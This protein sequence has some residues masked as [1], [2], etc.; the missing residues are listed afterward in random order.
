MLQQGK[1]T[2][3]YG[4][5]ENQDETFSSLTTLD[6][7]LIDE[8]QIVTFDDEFIAYIITGNGKINGQN[9]VNGDLI[10]GH[11]M[12]FLAETDSQIIIVRKNSK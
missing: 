7:G 2:R 9:V 11:D 10:R 3:V 8:N 1:I 6:V 5:D 12:Q 4:G